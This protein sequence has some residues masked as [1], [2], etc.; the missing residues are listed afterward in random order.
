MDRKEKFSVTLTNNK[1]S[2]TVRRGGDHGA[3]GYMGFS[4]R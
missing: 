1:K 4:R 3:K 2:P